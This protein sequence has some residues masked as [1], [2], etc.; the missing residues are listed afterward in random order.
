MIRRFHRDVSSW[1]IAKGAITEISAGS[2]YQA[3]L[4]RALQ[5][6]GPELLHITDREENEGKSPDAGETVTYGLRTLPETIVIF[7]REFSVTL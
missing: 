2:I 1:E 6:N 3:A 5:Q 4:R 7:H